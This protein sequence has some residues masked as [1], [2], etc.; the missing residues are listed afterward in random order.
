MSAHDL[1]RRVLVLAPT[2]RDAANTTQIL[3][4]AGIATTVCADVA[5]LLEQL[6]VGAGAVVVTEESLAVERAARLAGFLQ[7]Q[8]EWS[9]LPFIAVTRGGPDSA[10]AVQSLIA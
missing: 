6:A 1:E 4:A 8:P 9:D 5:G 7:E 3:A 10:A 2:V